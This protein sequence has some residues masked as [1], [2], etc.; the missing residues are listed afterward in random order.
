MSEINHNTILSTPL[1]VDGESAK[2]GSSTIDNV[3]NA[4]TESLIQMVECKF[5]L[6]TNDDNTF[7][8]QEDILPSINFSDD[9][10][11]TDEERML[12]YD[13]AMHFKRLGSL[14]HA[15][16]CFLGCL[17]GLQPSSKSKFTMLPQCLTHVAELYAHSEDYQ[18]AVE[19]M[20]AAKLYYEI[21]IIET[22]IQVDEYKKETDS[23]YRPL[24]LDPCL[25]E[26]K[27]ANEYEKLSYS[28]LEHKKFQLALDY[29]GK[30]TKLRQQV[31]GDDHPITGKSLDLFT[32]IYAEMG[33]C[34]YGE[35]L[36]KYGDLTKVIEEEKKGNRD[37]LV[38]VMAEEHEKEPVKE[39]IVIIVIVSFLLLW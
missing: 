27:R 19:F 1:Q 23:G 2:S 17:Q 8:E 6:S 29:C 32:L 25:D 10:D 30:A 18:R 36:Q 39:V 16:L 31:Y 12:L 13:K 24:D 38:N 28:C 7:P 11:L 14:N 21:A 26:A 3:K 33:K 5:P 20:Q 15:L 9:D 35:A 22:G 34:Q 37:E 4:S